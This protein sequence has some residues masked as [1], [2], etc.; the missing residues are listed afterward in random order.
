M[1]VLVVESDLGGARALRK[2][3][4]GRGH[5]VHTCFSDPYDVQGC[6]ALDPEVGCPLDTEPIDVVVDVR[7]FPHPAPRS[8]EQGATCGIRKRVPLVV[9][10]PKGTSPYTRW[11]SAVVDGG[12]EEIAD[13]VEAT[14]G[15]RSPAHQEVVDAALDA[16]MPGEGATAFVSR[17]SGRL[18]VALSLPP[19]TSSVE[20]ER[21]TLKVVAAVR[22]FDPETPVLDV[23]LEGSTA[24]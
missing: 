20:A 3:L 18:H 24:P 15:A 12:T 10:S 16:A 14:D 11:A 13:A 17:Q 9:A 4:V 2:T 1:K 7:G 6:T 21:V 8:L 23:G 19:D 5:D 22:A